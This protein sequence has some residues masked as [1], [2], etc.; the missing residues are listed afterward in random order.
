MHEDGVEISAVSG[1]AGKVWS[2]RSAGTKLS[3][4]LPAPARYQSV[5]QLESLE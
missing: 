5:G 4:G 1:E 2:R 3:L